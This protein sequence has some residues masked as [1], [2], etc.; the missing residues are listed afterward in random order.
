[1]MIDE[2][3]KDL[4]TMHPTNDAIEEEA[5]ESFVKH[6]TDDAIEEE[7]ESF[8]EKPVVIDDTV[9]PMDVM[10]EADF[11]GWN[12]ELKD[13][14]D[15]GSGLVAR[16][17]DVPI[18]VRKTFMEILKEAATGGDLN[19]ALQVTLSIAPIFQ[20]D[21]PYKIKYNSISDQEFKEKFWSSHEHEVTAI[22][23]DYSSG[24]LAFVTGYQSFLDGV[25]TKTFTLTTADIDRY[26][27][28]FTPYCTYAEAVDEYKST[29]PK[30]EKEK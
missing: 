19:P 29:L 17:S 28:R 8:D 26:D 23:V 5:L 21:R 11:D 24:G 22:C 25:K 12:V 9:V 15:N 3:I 10:E 4:K 14:D 6:P 7:V 20:V 27:I 30:E 2:S 16:P 18:S 13:S 1:M